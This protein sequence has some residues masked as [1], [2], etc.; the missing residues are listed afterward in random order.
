MYSMSI[1]IKC[2]Y[3]CASYH[4]TLTIKFP[5]TGW[6]LTFTIS[7]IACREEDLTY[8]LFFWEFLSYLTKWLVK[9][10]NFFQVKS[11]KSIKSAPSHFHMAMLIKTLNNFELLLMY[12]V[13]VWSESKHIISSLGKNRIKIFKKLI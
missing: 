12:Y 11:F 4:S 9:F 6:D 5:A 3:A 1:F 2:I 10:F 13:L 7:M 8:T